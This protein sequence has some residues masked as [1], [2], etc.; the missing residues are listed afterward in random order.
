MNLY[1]TIV[2]QLKD[3]MRQKDTDTLNTLRYIKGIIDNKT[4]LA[5]PVEA[6]DENIIAM[7][8]PIVRDLNVT[9]EASEGDGKIRLKKEIELLSSFLPKMLSHEE[10][11]NIIMKESLSTIKDTMTYF[12]THYFKQYDASYI[13]SKF[14]G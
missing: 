7:I 11:D 5:K 4:R 8:T 6:S 2:S 3:A 14:K 1:A 12:N 10:I 9:Y 13:A